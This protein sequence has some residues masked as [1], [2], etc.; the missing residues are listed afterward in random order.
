MNS[1]LHLLLQPN[2]VLDNLSCHKQ[3]SLDSVSKSQQTGIY[4]I[5][6]IL[7]H[8]ISLYTRHAN[9]F[10]PFI[11]NLPECH[12]QCQTQTPKH[13][14]A[15]LFLITWLITQRTL[16]MK[17]ALPHPHPKARLSPESP[18]EAPRE[19]CQPLCPSQQARPCHNDQS[20]CRHV[21]AYK[22]IFV[23]FRE[24]L[25][26]VVVGVSVELGSVLAYTS[27]AGLSVAA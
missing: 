26:R 11:I 22:P 19:N 9:L 8:V 13:S 16:I 18:Q 20:L 2:I 3:T 15:L 21:P 25:R 14:S 12:I 27:A 10:R 23:T 7:S 1:K 24:K 4:V 17:R 6:A 5:P